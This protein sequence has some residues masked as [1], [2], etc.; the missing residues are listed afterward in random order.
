TE[1]AGVPMQDLNNIIY[2][3]LNS[4]ILRLED[5]Y[6]DV[7]DEID[8]MYLN[9]RENADMGSVAQVVRAILDSSH[10]SA[11]DVSVIVP[12][13]LLVEQK[14]TE[15]LFDAVMVG[16]A[17]ISLM[18]GGLGI[19]NIMLASILERKREIGVRP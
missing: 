12:A 17:S 16:I 15:R 1:V 13:V 3:P 18:V 6:S 7:R 5:N 19:M 8:G 10:H 2:V 14:R 4:A 9:V 11:G